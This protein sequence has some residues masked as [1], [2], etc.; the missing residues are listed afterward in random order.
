MAIVDRY[1][2]VNVLNQRQLMKKINVLKL[3]PLGATLSLLAAFGGS[4]YGQDDQN[5]MELETFVTTGSLIPTAGD[6]PLAPVSIVSSADIETSGVAS[7]VLEVIRKTTPQF[8]G[9][10]NLGQSN[11]N[12]GSSTTGGGSVI[13]LRNT[14]TLVLVN[15]RRVAF[16]P[17]SGSGG[18]T[19]VDVNQIPLVA[20]ERIEIL[21]DGASAT[22][23]TD[24]T[25]GV[26]NIILKNN[27][28]GFQLGGRYSISDNTGNW[29]EHKMYA[30]AGASAGKTRI[31]I[32]AEWS[33][34]DPLWQYQRDYSNPSY[35]TPTFGGVVNDA[36][37]NGFVLNPNLEAPA[38]NLNLSTQQLIDQEIYISVD[39]FDLLDGVG[40]TEQYAF[41]LADYVTILVENER[42]LISA[43][44]THQ[45]NDTTELFA[46]LLYSDQATFSQI[47]AQPLS[48][49]I[50]A[51]HPYNPWDMA[52][53]A[54]NRFVEFPRQYFYDT[55]ALRLVG[56]V[57]GEIAEGWTYEVGI[58]L[59][60]A[61]QDYRN[62]GVIEST[63]LNEA[64]GIDAT[65]DDR[66]AINFF[67][68]NVDSDVIAA[69]R[70]V[71]VANSKFE[72]TLI[73]IDFRLNG[74][75]FDLPA[76]PVAIAMGGEYR[77]EEL[78]G[79]A[80]LFS[81]PPLRWTGA[82][83]IQPF[84]AERDITSLFA[85][86]RVPVFGEDHD[87]DLIHKLDLS[88]A[89]RYESYSDTDD[90]LVFKV[91]FRM[92]I[93]EDEL[94][95]R[96]TWGESFNAPSLYSLF[97][98]SDQGF[99]S[100]QALIPLGETETQQWGQA[101]FRGGSNPELE[102]TESDSF[103]LGLVYSPKAVEGLALEL[104]YWNISEDNLVATP[105]A[106]TILQSVED[107]GLDSPY[108]DNVRFGSFEGSKVTGPGQVFPASPLNTFVTAGVGNFSSQDLDGIDAVI[109]YAKTLEG[110][111]FDVKAVFTWFNSYEIQI[112]PDD[113]PQ[114]TA[115]EAT[116]LNGTIPRWRTY[117]T[118]TYR[119]GQMSF[120]A[121]LT[122][123]PSMPYEFAPEG[124][125][126]DQYT[127]LDLAVG[128]S[129]EENM[130]I[131]DGLRLRVGVN[132]VTN[133]MPPLARELFNEA[134]AD[135]ATYDP[136][137]RLFF[138]EGSYSF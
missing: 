125:E 83:T 76:G 66:P 77:E 27:Y 20:I 65:G 130:G 3:F 46:D 16:S 8:V 79:D 132:N 45:I 92:E 29:S 100:P 133:E 128:Y 40:D 113:D 49:S 51:N 4:L 91:G 126:M 31:N 34:S 12:I 121:G 15:G 39:I 104:T 19:F 63:A 103:T 118:G 37:F 11:A 131:L 82:T 123:I 41:N 96:G 127:T 17:I 115:G 137:G 42:K 61:T 138:I 135:V 98:P 68:R 22:Y 93:L 89:T 57:R 24:A 21:Q 78:S 111:S 6:I 102:P 71:G 32:V 18:F 105:P 134:N 99:T 58:N 97:G 85:E 124:A 48:L 7:N 5:L 33:K 74:E 80:D 64:A 1:Y 84:S 81:R 136:I 13:S 112:L 9:N 116:D 87:L 2:T 117:I 55:T 94:V 36:D 25:S 110:S 23:G 30:A 53:T 106:S 28:E 75:L 72:S 101:E 88:L 43:T 70:A 62:P 50:P 107:L 119:I 120:T 52:V 122:H 60:E 90:P 69:S 14:Q 95:F 56:G 86:A 109:G 73:S 10:S 67:D 114:E 54:R 129:F 59:N 38:F 44:V 47:N 108:A 26:V 35:G